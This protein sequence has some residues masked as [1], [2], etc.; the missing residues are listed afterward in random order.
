L[1][2]L[3]R[4]APAT[5]IRGAASRSG[6]R[7]WRPVTDG[8]AILLTVIAF[9]TF[10][11]LVVGYRFLLEF[12]YPSI[13]MLNFL[14]IGFFM[15]M[16]ADLHV[17]RAE[18]VDIN[19]MIAIGFGLLS[20]KNDRPRPRGED[21]YRFIRNA[22]PIPRQPM[23]PIPMRHPPIMNPAPT[24][25][26]PPRAIPLNNHVAPIQQSPAPMQH[27]APRNIEPPEPHVELAMRLSQLPESTRVRR[28]VCGYCGW[29]LT[30]KYYETTYCTVDGQYSVI[31]CPNCWRPVTQ[32]IPVEMR[33]RS[34]LSRSR[35]QYLRKKADALREAKRLLE[36]TQQSQAQA[37]PQ[38]EVEAEVNHAVPINANGRKRVKLID[39]DLVKCK[40]CPYF[41]AFE[42]GGDSGECVI[43]HLDVSGNSTICSERMLEMLLKIP[44]A[45]IM[46]QG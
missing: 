46:S 37:K 42:E 19:A 32:P 22:T 20:R 18:T 28:F 15:S 43:K 38:V 33:M 26:H 36:E 13:A 12:F 17:L 44:I 6:S 41:S 35:L 1:E 9:V 2:A 45:E 10:S 8:L 4:L 3:A 40:T 5:P 25:P 27:A 7:A 16:A 24:Q 39:Y 14:A 23:I 21:E 29:D 30:I 11:Y 31:V 34:V